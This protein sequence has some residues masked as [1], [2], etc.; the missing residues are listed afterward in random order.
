MSL[1][2]HVLAGS[3][4]AVVMTA[5]A[6]EAQPNAPRVT[7]INRA[8]AAQ[9]LAAAGASAIATLQAYLRARGH[10][11]ATV[12][13]LA[14]VASEQ[15]AAGVTHLRLEQRVGDLQVYGVY[16]KA[17]LNARGELI[18][19]IE[20]LVAIPAATAVPAAIGEPQALAASLR[21]LFGDQVLPPGLA[22]REGSTAIF[23]RT[24]FFHRGPRVTPVAIPRG[25]GLLGVAYLVE[26]WTAKRNLL[27]HTLVGGDGQILNEE[28]RTNH[29]SYKV[30]AV[31]PETSAQAAASG[32]GAGN[33]ESPSG[34]LFA[35]AQTS[36]NIIGN[37][38]NAYVDADANNTPDGGGTPVGD[39]N[40]LATADLAASPATADNRAVAVQNLFY[41]NNVIHDT[42]FRHGFSEAA[43]N[44]QEQNFTGTGEDSDSVNAEAQDG[45][46]TDN[47]NFAT[48]V[49]G[50]NPRMQMFLWNPL[51]THEV[52]ISGSPAADG[53]YLAQGMAFGPSLDAAGLS[54]PLRLADD[55]A[56]SYLAC[57][58]L[59]KGSLEGAVAI[60]DRG[61]CD[62]TDKV[63][64]A[65]R[66]GAV[67]VIVVNNVDGA[68]F[69]GSGTGG[70]FK[71]PSVMVSLADGATIKT[72]AGVGTATLR[73]KATAPPMRDSALDSDVVWHEYGHGLTWRMIG[74]MSG[75]VAGA[76][77]EGMSDV[78]ALLVNGN[79]VVGEYAASDPAGIRS[80]PYTD[81]PAHLWRLQRDR[82]A[83]RRR[84]L[85]R[86]R[87]AAARE[88]P[89]RGP[90]DG[91]AAHLPR[92]RHELHA[93]YAVLRGHAR[94]HPGGVANP[95][96]LPG[97]GRVR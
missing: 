96:R 62:F 5:S 78:L 23:E 2:R 69:S 68:I 72:A 45:S 65:Q 75:P 30:F 51:G 36:V 50:Q 86:H 1:S 25:D 39:G 24:P 38:V 88:L 37:N 46:G 16:V 48:P 12:A 60:V 91:H 54:G 92:G 73:L 17:S 95:A 19:V 97:V 64:N 77:G 55:G 26:T 59:P 94:R 21:H 76:I 52:V 47:A 40:F 80:A 93:G 82:R 90:D 71:A 70:G 4:L 35:T 43:G 49:E 6:A 20:N 22:R 14:L 42:L 28:S 15:T 10:G 74:G 61:A 83:L 34:W 58:R 8:T 67:G 87:L 7:R 85:R 56:G 81:Y 13:S 41:L 63:I 44:F 3:F 31:D 9:P 84:N 32:P 27:H 29:D 33:A 57:S 11:S 18:S 53:T 89:G 66:A 79:D